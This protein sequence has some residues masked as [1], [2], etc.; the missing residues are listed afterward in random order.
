MTPYL[1][2][3]V[4]AA[5]NQWLSIRRPGCPGRASHA[6]STASAGRADEASRGSA[7]RE[8]ARGRPLECCILFLALTKTNEAD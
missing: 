8:A 2:G 4:K 5:H 1:V 6:S 3:A 7:P